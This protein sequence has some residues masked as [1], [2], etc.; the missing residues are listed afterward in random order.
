MELVSNFSNRMGGVMTFIAN[1][2]FLL[3]VAKGKIPRH[4]AFFINAY[5]SDVGTGDYPQT[6]WPEKGVLYVPPTEPRLHDVASDD[7]ADVGEV[8]TS[9]TATGGSQTT[10]VDSGALFTLTVSVGDAVI[11]DTTYEHSIVT[12]VTDTTLTTEATRHSG[13]LA[14][15]GDAYRIVRATST[16]ASFVHIH[17]LD[18]D[19]VWGEEFVVMNG[20]SN[21]ATVAEMWRINIMHIDGAASRD[22]TNVGKITATAQTD[23][24]VTAS[25]EEATGHAAQA[26]FTVPSNKTGY[27][28]MAKADASRRT[29]TSD[30]TTE[31]EMWMV[32]H[33]RSGKSGS[34]RVDVAGL[35]L[36]GTSRI[37]EQYLLPLELLSETDLEIRIVY[38]SDSNMKLMAGL[39]IILVDNE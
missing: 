8:R 39:G 33:A 3:E 17:Y 9:G 13:L 12:A 38:V 34:R 18:D 10:L 1:R 6:I 4:S 22:A 25:I 26:F 11:N 24:T 27:L 30:A 20:I 35:N 23:G 16:G 31:F 14:A 36:R 29:T 19:F 37:N 15:N 5:A 28:V 32:P 7:A 21:V 2:D